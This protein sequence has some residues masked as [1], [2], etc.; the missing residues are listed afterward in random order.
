MTS[1]C[2]RK[3]Q[4]HVWDLIRNR[5]YWYPVWGQVHDRVETPVYEMIH[6]VPLRGIR[7]QL[8]SELAW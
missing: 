3:I 7:D 6:R 8:E 2:D 5:I 4:E 1:I